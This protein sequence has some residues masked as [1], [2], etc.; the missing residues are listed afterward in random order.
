[1]KSILRILVFMFLTTTLSTSY[2]NSYILVAAPC[3]DFV[4]M[5]DSSGSGFNFYSS[6]Y[7]DT[8]NPITAYSWNF[9]DGFTSTI[10]NPS[11]AL[12]FTYPNTVCLSLT[13]ADGTNCEYCRVVGTAGTFANCIDSTYY[14]PVAICSF[15]YAPVCACGITYT[16][17]C[18]ALN[19]GATQWTNGGCPTLACDP[20]FTASTSGCTVALA[21]ISM[22]SPPPAISFTM[23]DGTVVAGT[24]AIWTAPANGTYIFTSSLPCMGA[25]YSSS[26]TIV[27]TGCAPAT[28]TPPVATDTTFL[29]SVGTTITLIAGD[30]LGLTP[31]FV[32]PTG[33]PITVTTYDSSSVAG[34][35]SVSISSAGTYIITGD[36]TLSDT[37]YATVFITVCASDGECTVYTITVVIYPRLGSSVNESNLLGA[38]N[39]YPNTTTN[40]INIETTSNVKQALTLTIID[41][42]GHKLYAENINFNVGKSTKTLDC[43][44]LASGIYFVQ[45][46]NGVST[47]TF[48]I[49]KK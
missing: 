3:G 47:Q 22:T 1:M 6:T 43:Q 18:I 21:A 39:Y 20:T 8:I 29:G 26:V 23:P 45:Y 49:I 14:N 41:I 40:T 27:V 34:W 48:K 42:T 11:H 44:A 12:S 13:F 15:L 19:N 24:S 9:S 46:S 37:T 28:P 30:T 5:P 10:A 31:I 17:D 25:I 4:A 35:G 36:S 2:A 7:S 33:L 32:D 16:N 38:I